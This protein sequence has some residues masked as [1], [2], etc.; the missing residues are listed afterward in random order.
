MYRNVIFGCAACLY[1]RSAIFEKLMTIVQIFGYIHIFEAN[2]FNLNYHM[3]SI[4]W[5][6]CVLFV[7]LV[8]PRC[9]A[10]LYKELNWSSKPSVIDD[11]VK[12]LG[13]E[14]PPWEEMMAKLKKYYSQ[15]DNYSLTHFWSAMVVPTVVKEVSQSITVSEVLL[16]HIIYFAMKLAKHMIQII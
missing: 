14:S 4:C 5:L 11:M 2:R 7:S 12:K 10:S 3:L 16:L 9:M 1:C 8:I 6:N 13:S 15:Y